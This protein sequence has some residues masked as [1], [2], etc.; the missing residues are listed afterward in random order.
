MLRFIFTRLSLVI[1][2]F[3]GITLLAFFLV[4]LVPGD[5]IETMAGERGIDAARHA[6]LLTEYGLDR[7]LL[8]QYGK[9]IERVVQGD[10]GKS[11]VTRENV[12]TEFGQLF[13]ATIELAL[14]AILIALIVGLPAGII[15]AVKRNSIFDHG[16]MGISLTGYSMPIFWWGLLLILLFSVQLGITPVSGRISVQYFIEPV[17]GFLTID[18]LLAGGIDA[19]WSALSHLVL[20]AIVLVACDSPQLVSFN[21]PE[22]CEPRVEGLA[23]FSE[24]TARCVEG[25]VLCVESEVDGRA[26][27]Y[28][29]SNDDNCVC[30]APARVT[31]ADA[32]AVGPASLADGDAGL[33]DVDAE[34]RPIRLDRGRGGRGALSQRRR[35][36]AAGHGLWS[37]RCTQPRHRDRRQGYPLRSGLQRFGQPPGRRAVLD[38]ERDH[39]R[40]RAVLR[41]ARRPDL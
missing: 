39:D 36:R 12:L 1:P 41:R 26:W 38:R 27:T 5:P 40:G 30:S 31:L 14:C 11:I 6:Q 15:A 18:S 4:R 20:P 29:V 19:F 35:R 3:I 17:T 7:P 24:A 33:G 8:V 21:T 37:A 10:L 13:P 32:G 22:L 34:G 2:T 28:S 23:T 25:C 16:V 9:Y